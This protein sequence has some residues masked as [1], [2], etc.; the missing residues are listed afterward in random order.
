MARRI[1]A[2]D[3]FIPAAQWQYR[4]LI[5]MGNCHGF[6][7]QALASRTGKT[8][9]EIERMLEE[10]GGKAIRQDAPSTNGQGSAA[11]AG[12]LPFPAGG[13]VRRPQADGG[14]V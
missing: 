10:A 2:M 1:S 14:P 12:G 6:L 11:G 9:R 5:E 7:M 8:R 3:Y 13:A 4:K